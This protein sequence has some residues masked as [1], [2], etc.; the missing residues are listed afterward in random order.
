MCLLTHYSF[1]GERY[2]LNKTCLF[3]YIYSANSLKY[4]EFGREYLLWNGYQ[5]FK[6]FINVIT[7]QDIL[8]YN[9]HLKGYTQITESLK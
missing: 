6:D 3:H 2:V 9:S 4:N 7:S 8:V 1:D 5:N